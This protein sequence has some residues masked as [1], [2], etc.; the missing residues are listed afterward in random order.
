ML[1]DKELYGGFTTPLDR[2]P[3]QMTLNRKLI[4]NVAPTGAFTTKEQNPLHPLTSEQIVDAVVESYNAGAS[5]WHVHV[6]GKDGLTTKDPKDFKR[7]IDLVLERCPDI[8]TSVIP[9][10][11][12]SS[13][14]V[15]QIKPMVDYLTD[16]GPR[17][18]QTAVLLIQTMSF[19]EKFSF[20]VN[21]ALFTGV[22]DYLE[23]RGVRP[24][25]QVHSYGGMR[26]VCDWALA[27]GIAR[28]PY[29]FNIMSGYHGFS[30]GSPPAPDPWNYIYM[31]T[32]Q[33]TIPR[34]SCVGACCGGR[35]WLPFANQAII[36][37]FDS[38][39]IGME[40]A[41]YMYPH[42]DLKIERCADVVRKIATIAHELGREIATPAEARQIMGIRK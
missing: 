8:I 14:G 42:K 30:H 10:A 33:Q 26:D 29:L 3:P 37:G 5:V 16:A 35:N 11:N 38:V 36:L 9:Y 40:D 39:R 20:V 13:Q 27:K 12:V 2:E 28:K 32:M 25:F 1:T 23:S 15:E 34:E 18:M 7:T 41:V 21:E 19:S 17:Y 4:I 31:M 6:R 22:V 24:E